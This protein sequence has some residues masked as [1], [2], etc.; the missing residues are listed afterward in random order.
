MAESFLDRLRRLVLSIYGKFC[1][2]V[3]FPVDGVSRLPFWESTIQ[4]V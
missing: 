2:L 1:L 3:G 4:G